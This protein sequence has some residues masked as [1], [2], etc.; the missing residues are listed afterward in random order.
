LSAKNKTVQADVAHVDFRIIIIIQK[1]VRQ[2][3]RYL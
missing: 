1:Q 3:D 2:Y